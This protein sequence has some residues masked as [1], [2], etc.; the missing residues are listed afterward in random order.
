MFYVCVHKFDVTGVIGNFLGTKLGLT[1]EEGLM[2]RQ[3]ATCNR[4]QRTIP[5][6]NKC[7]LA[8]VPPT[9]P[10]PSRS[11]PCQDTPPSISSRRCPDVILAPR[12]SAVPVPLRLCHTPMLTGELRASNP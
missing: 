6:S 11:S 1:F 7:H 5:M 3:T 4:A 12:R 10:P 2:Q 9:W 8:A